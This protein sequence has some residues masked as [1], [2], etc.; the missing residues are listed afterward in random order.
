M[1]LGRQMIEVSEDDLRIL[2]LGLCGDVREAETLAEYYEQCCWGC[3]WNIRKWYENTEGM[4][5]D[6][7]EEVLKFIE[8]EGLTIEEDCNIY[9]SMRNGGVWFEYY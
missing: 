8:E 6:S 7:K 2:F 5:F 4:Y 3:D 9:V 1:I